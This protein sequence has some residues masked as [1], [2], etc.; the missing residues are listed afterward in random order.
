MIKRYVND[1]SQNTYLHIEKGDA[2]LIDAAADV[3][4]I[5]KDLQ[6]AS[7]TLRAVLLTHGHYDHIVSLEEIRKTF[8]VPIHIHKDDEDFLHDP[9]LNLSKLFGKAFV[10]GTDAHIE[11]HTEEDT[12]TFGKLRVMIHHAPGHTRGSTLFQI[13]DAL[14]TG[15]TLFKSSIGRTDLPGGDEHALAA[16]LARL[17]EDLPEKLRIFPGHGEESLL[18]AE[19]RDNPHL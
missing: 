19:R 1:F 4:A 15:D 2:V 16:S 13:G 5:K 17:K 12:L 6:E 7:A 9:G 3:A 18:K 10:L 8:D 14:Y 11:T